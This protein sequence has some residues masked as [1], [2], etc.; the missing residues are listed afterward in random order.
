[1]QAGII[2][3]FG[4]RAGRLVASASTP[5]TENDVAVGAPQGRGAKNT[6]LPLNLHTMS[7]PPPAQYRAFSSELQQ[8][9]FDSVRSLGVGQFLPIYI[10]CCLHFGEVLLRLRQRWSYRAN[11]SS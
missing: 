9:S 2:F 8:D 7:P 10:V 4:T 3:D 1:M 6:T 5:L 11:I